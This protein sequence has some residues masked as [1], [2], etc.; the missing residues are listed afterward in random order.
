[1]HLPHMLETEVFRFASGEVAY[2]LNSQK[3]TNIW[4]DLLYIPTKRNIKD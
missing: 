3:T 1:M 4:T 2:Q